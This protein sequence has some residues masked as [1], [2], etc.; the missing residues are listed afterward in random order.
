MVDEDWLSTMESRREEA[1]PVSVNPPGALDADATPAAPAPSSP[2][3]ERRLGPSTRLP[4]AV[5]A[6]V[7][8]LGMGA[9]LAVGHLVAGVLTANASPFLAVGN[10]AIDLAPAPVKDFAIRTFGTHDKLVLIGGMAIVLL[11]FAVIAGLLSRRVPWPGTVLAVALGGLAVA[12]VLTRPDLG[13]IDLLAPAASLVVGVVVFRWLHAL[14]VHRRARS[15]D[16][17]WTETGA[18]RRRFL[19]MSAGIAAGAGVAAAGGQL[20]ANQ[21]DVEGSN[22]VLGPLTPAK[23][24]PPIPA[25]ADFAQLGTPPFIT[26]NRDFYRVDTALSVPRVRAEDWALRIHGAVDDEVVLRYADIRRMPL[27]ERT[28][29]ITCVSNEV[30]GS[31]V[32]TSNFIG[33]PLRD[34][35]ARAGV[36]PGA[37]QLFSTSVD[38][39]TCG[40]PMAEVLDRGLLAIGMNGKPLP[41]E[42]GFPARMVVP[43]L[44][45]FASATKWVVDLELNRF[46]DKQAYWVKRGWAQLAPIKTQSRIDTPAAF[47]TV[48]AGR[49]TIAGIA[50]A[51]H[52][53][54]A[55]V[56]VRA[57][58][59]PWQ[60]AEL[61]T[62][63]N[64][65]TWRMWHAELNLARGQHTVECR[66]T[67]Q[68]GATQT[69]SRVPPLPDGATGWH[70]I[71]FTVE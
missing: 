19:A 67:D 34:I 8:V 38:G 28:V 36:K 16:D 1:T 35:L 2:S 70:S 60:T 48:P 65:D 20:L 15:E 56:E 24:A 37:E 58:G 30:G 59:G 26:S 51:Q 5:A 61:A 39:W 33:V 4:S 49:V 44:Y 41:I 7:G 21:I 11:G 54:I 6:L 66:A 23:P 40:T 63:V 55:K 32:S 17:T 64:L 14:A 18:S 31:Y 22:T 3:P 71:Q 52:R 68:T 43:G 57:D 62:E 53:G 50:Y 12:A 45:G 25:G 47:A 69:D 27:A 29:T 13:L 9:A 46:A 10:T 42:H